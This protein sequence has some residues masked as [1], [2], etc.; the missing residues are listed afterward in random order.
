MQL[1][2]KLFMLE[3]PTSQREQCG[4]VHISITIHYVEET[5]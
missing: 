3:Q 2:I 1:R 4:A 5:C